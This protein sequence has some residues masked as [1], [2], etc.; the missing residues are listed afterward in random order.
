MKHLI[1]DDD[2]E[3]IST[4]LTQ[5]YAIADV[6]MD[7]H[8]QRKDGDDHMTANTLWAMQFMIDDVRNQLRAA[9]IM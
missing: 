8:G 6:L 5:L 9:E 2:Y 7:K 4:K 3:K 1:N